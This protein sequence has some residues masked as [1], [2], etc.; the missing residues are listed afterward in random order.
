M[1]RWRTTLVLLVALLTAGTASAPPAAAQGRVEVSDATGQARASASGQTVLTVSGTGFQSV[2]GG[3]GGIYVVFGWVDDP[4]GGTWRPSLGGLTG[5]DYLY[6]PDAESA[7]NAGHQRFVAFPGSDTASAA[8]GGLIAA[9][10]T[11]STTLVVP[12]AQFD[13]VDRSG[14]TR[15]VDCLEVT[16]GVI[17]FGAHGVVNATN[18]TFTPVTFTTAGTTS[19]TATAD[20]AEPTATSA[21]GLATLG[22]DRRTTTAGQVLG[23]TGQGFLAGEQVVVTLDAGDAAVG[24]LVAGTHGE[25]AGVLQLPADL[26]AGT[27]ALTVTGAASGL[28]A[29]TELTVTAAQATA[30]TT[31]DGSGVS[32]WAVVAVAVTGTVLLALLVATTVAAWR[33]RARLR[34]RRRAVSAP[35]GAP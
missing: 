7:D 6:V 11:W 18:E 8:N 2:E 4:Q 34:A 33:D 25:V 27:H 23:F 28:V 30:V 5:E 17:T 24:P 10:G 19:E 16:C 22:V 9:D 14:A 26:R 13:A 29:S 3:F 12:E 1:T 15:T 21:A 31:S 32:T 35:V 20:A